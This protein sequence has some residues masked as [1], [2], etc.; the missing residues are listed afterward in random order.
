MINPNDIK[1][2][3]SENGRKDL[4]KEFVSE[5]ENGKDDVKEGGNDNE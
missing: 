2:I 5:F 4:D 1:K 3:D